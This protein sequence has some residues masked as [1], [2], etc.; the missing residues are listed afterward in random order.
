MVSEPG[1]PHGALCASSGATSLLTPRDVLHAETAASSAVKC[2]AERE[3]CKFAD[4][5]RRDRPV[6]EFDRAIGT[7][8]IGSS[9]GRCVV[10][11][12]SGTS[13]D[14]DDSGGKYEGRDGARSWGSGVA[15]NLNR[16]FCSRHPASKD[17]AGA[18]SGEGVAATRSCASER[19]FGFRPSTERESIPS[20]TSAS[21]AV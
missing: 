11:A 19:G 12:V 20:A 9:E 14:A 1:K 7:L 2:K 10:S 3:L 21:T 5:P 17:D 8:K 15:G 18:E 4:M 13:F 6:E 16:K